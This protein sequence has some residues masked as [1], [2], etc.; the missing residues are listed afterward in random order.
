[1]SLVHFS[2]H[3]NTVYHLNEI[4]QT[5]ELLEP[6]QKMCTMQLKHNDGNNKNKNSRKVRVELLHVM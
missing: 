2:S 3:I 6:F 1:M 5:P 4:Q